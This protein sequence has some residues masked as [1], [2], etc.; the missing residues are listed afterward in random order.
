MKRT[1]SRGPRQLIVLVEAELFAV[2]VDKAADLV[3]RQGLFKAAEQLRSAADSI[4][5]NVAEGY[6]RGL[7]KDGLNYF[8]IARA[9]C[10]ETESHLRV[11]GAKKR[12]PAD[13]IETLVDHV[14]RVRFL[15][16]RY[17]DSVARR[18][19]KRVPKAPTSHPSLPSPRSHPSP[20]P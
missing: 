19:K 11:F 5:A 1:R 20:S 17:A 7:T 2:A 12:I 18:M 8:R 16:M 9:S 6:G 14:I 4:Y 3:R 10:D 15:V 13:R